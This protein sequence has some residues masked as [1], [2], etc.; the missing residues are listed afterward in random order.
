MS[1]GEIR[2]MSAGG[3]SFASVSVGSNSGDSNL[4]V[5]S[6]CD[7]NFA[8]NS[9][10]DVSCDPWLF[11]VNELMHKKTVATCIKRTET[12]RNLMDLKRFTKSYFTRVTAIFWVRPAAFILMIYTPAGKSPAWNTAT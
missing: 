1:S 4:G 7:C 5:N 12:E 10:A 9:F 6:S 8:G 2:L 11:G 3:S